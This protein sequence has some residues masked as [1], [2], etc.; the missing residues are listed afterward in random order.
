M[1]SFVVI[2]EFHVA[3]TSKIEPLP[4]LAAFA[5]FQCLTKKTRPPKNKVY[6]DKTGR[7]GNYNPRGHGRRWNQ[8]AGCTKTSKHADH[9]RPRFWIP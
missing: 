3:N 7:I 9:A 6:S 8:G 2:D 5:S 1:I 4:I